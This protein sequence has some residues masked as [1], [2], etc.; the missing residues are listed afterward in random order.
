MRDTFT[1]RNDIKDLDMLKASTQQSHPSM[2]A[3]FARLNNCQKQS[4]N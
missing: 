3:D 1:N 2:R 4:I